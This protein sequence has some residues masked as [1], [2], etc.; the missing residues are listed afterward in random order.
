MNSKQI[1][2]RSLILLAMM[3]IV[4][5]AFGWAAK[6]ESIKKK[7]INKSF[8]VSLSDKLLTDN[9]YGSTTITHWNKNEVAIRV[10]IEARANN[11]KNAQA[12]LDRIQIELNKTGNIVSAVT[13][14]GQQRNQRF[15]I[16]YFIS[17]PSRLTIDLT[18]KYGNI[19]LP[20]KN[21]GRSM[22]QVKYGNLNAGSFTQPLDLEVKYGNVDIAD[23]DK[24]DMD[25]G[26][27]GNAS[28]GNANQLNVVSK[29]STMSIKKCVQIELE[30]RYGNVK[31]KSLNR[32]YMDI[33]YSEASIGFVGEEVS[34]DELAYSTLTIGEL[35]ANFKRLDVDARY[36]NLNVSILPSASFKLSAENM[37]ESNCNVSG[38]KNISSRREEQKHHSYEI[39]GGNKGRIYFNGNN[40]SNIS[41]SALENAK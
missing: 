1:K 24:A 19:F 30:N 7:E 33:K 12:T 25:F 28:I 4:S 40:Y 16:N 34:V 14:V 23:V 38:F 2:S 41:V 36:G 35:S 37:K 18:Q 32:G 21:E 11:D 13:S 3:L 8:N 39:N 9:R 29:Y 10:E 15:T 22:I 17:M 6:P 27:C 5:T 20:E 26:Y 31:L